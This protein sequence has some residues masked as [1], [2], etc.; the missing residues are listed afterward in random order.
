ML[1]RIQRQ[2]RRNPTLVVL[3]TLTLWWSA[4]CMIVYTAR[5]SSFVENSDISL[6][7]ENEQELFDGRRKRMNREKRSRREKYKQLQK[8]DSNFSMELPQLYLDT[9]QVEE[10]EAVSEEQKMETKKS[11]ITAN[12]EDLRQT[13]TSKQTKRRKKHTL[14]A[15][16]AKE[17]RLKTKPLDRNQI[18]IAAPSPTRNTSTPTLAKNLSTLRTLVTIVCGTNQ[19]PDQYQRNIFGR[20]LNQTKTMLKSLVYFSTFTTFRVILVTD[21]EDTYNQVLQ[22]IEDWPANYRSRLL[23]ERAELWTPPSEADPLLLERWRPCSWSKLFLLETLPFVDAAVY[24]DT[25]IL[26][27]APAEGLWDILDELEPPQALA[28]GPDPL[29]DRHKHRR[30]AGTVG[31][32]AGMMVMNFKALRAYRGQHGNFAQTILHYKNSF[33][34]HHDQD[35]LNAFLADHPELLHE[36]GARWNFSPS[37][38]LGGVLPCCTD[39]G[40][41]VIHG[42]D[43]TFVRGIEMIFQ[44]IYE[45]LLALPL[46]S[47]GASDLLR[48][49]EDQFSR[50]DRQGL[51]STCKKVWGIQDI[52][53]KHIQDL[54]KLEEKEGRGT[55]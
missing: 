20:Q 33:A 43:A 42:F 12:I 45:R 14:S 52:L 27:L 40:V 22:Q 30:Y 17:N 34:N 54:A 46:D 31:L 38:C 8:S 11:K 51:S 48:S 3:V 32:S 6:D 39:T 5:A 36:L 18:E 28:L 41:T 29:Y 21:T 53:L 23:F 26:F 55:V 13:R 19:R 9:R 24:V 47:G 50:V 35:T 44:V 2:L 15:K 49:L 37:Q 16:K 25:D 4:A 10:N 1:I 7:L